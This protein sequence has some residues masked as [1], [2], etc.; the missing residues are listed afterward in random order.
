MTHIA[1]VSITGEHTAASSVAVRSRRQ[2]AS[3]ILM[4]GLALERRRVRKLIQRAAVALLM[5]TDEHGAAFGRP[6]LPLLLDNDSH[7][8]FL[9]HQN[10]RKVRQVAARPQMCLT[11]TSGNCYLVVVGSANASRDVELIRRLWRPTYRAWFPEGRDDREA[12]VLRVAVERIDYWEPPR[13]RFVRL[14]QAVKAVVTRRSVD[15]PMK[16][17][18]GL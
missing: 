3:E 9:T 14:L 12:A 1:S 8:Y 2:R 5:T 18:D 4:P 17:I 15:T 7:I 16:S 11:L 13:S 6:M 10:S